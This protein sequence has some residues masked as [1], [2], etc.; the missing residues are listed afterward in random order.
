MDSLNFL[1]E[2]ET[3]MVN[4][5]SEEVQVRDTKDALV[6]VDIDE[7][8]SKTVYNSLM[9]CSGVKLATRTSSM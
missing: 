5:M 1:G 2:G 6:G 3:M 7:R 9:C 8:H 4:V